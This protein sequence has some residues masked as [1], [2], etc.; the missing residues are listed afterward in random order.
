MLKCGSPSARSHCANLVS[1]VVER[2]FANL[3]HCEEKP[4][5]MDS[6]KVE[7][8][9]SILRRFLEQVTDVI[10]TKDCQR[11]WARLEQFYGMVADIATSGPL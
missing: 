6:T 7:R 9:R 5:M 2:A 11:Q 10:F 8:L 4:E 1:G 3:A